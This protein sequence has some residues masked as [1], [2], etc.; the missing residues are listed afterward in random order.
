MAKNQLLFDL[1]KGAIDT[2]QQ[3]NRENPN[4]KTA[5][6]SIF[7]L[8][9][10]KVNDM[11]QNAANGKGSGK[12]SLIDLFQKTVQDVRQQNKANPN[13]DT[14]PKSLFNQIVKTVDQYRGGNGKMEFSG[15]IQEYNVD[16][17]NISPSAL[18]EIKKEFVLEK[19][20]LHKKYA[21]LL[22]RFNQR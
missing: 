21:R 2:T 19:R 17:R 22:Q 16:T 12:K 6:E 4:Q 14:A 1:I 5:A 9:R 15:L 18:K 11:Q 7:N 10:D 13:E 20:A 3:R 8:L